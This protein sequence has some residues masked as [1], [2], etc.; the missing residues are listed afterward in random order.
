[1]SVTVLFVRT[2]NICRASLAERLFRARSRPNARVLT[3]TAQVHAVEGY[4]MDRADVHALRE[5]GCDCQRHLLQYVNE[6][7]IKEA[8]LI[9]G[10]EAAHRDTA[11]RPAPPNM[12]PAFT[13]QEFARLGAEPALATSVAQAN[14]VTAP[15]SGGRGSHVEAAAAVHACDGANEK[16]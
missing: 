10:V 5:P 4:P 14:K 11:L 6:S 1:V 8:D 13:L 7:S 12:R 3:H 2:G 15:S 9:L 16:V